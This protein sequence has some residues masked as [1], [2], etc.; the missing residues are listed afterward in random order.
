M[1][2]APFVVLSFI[3]IFFSGCEASKCP[4][5]WTITMGSCRNLNATKYQG[6][7]YEQSRSTSFIPG[8]LCVCTT[9]NYTIDT[10]PAGYVGVH[11]GCDYFKVGGPPTVLDGKAAVTSPQY[12]GLS[13]SFF[14]PVGSDINYQVVD[15][16]Y[17]SYTIIVTCTKDQ[18]D[19][20]I[21]I[22]SR[23]KVIDPQLFN[24]LLARIS[25]MGFDYSD[26][27][28]TPQGT[29]CIGQGY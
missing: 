9:A 23:A 27:I 13:V 11:N 3:V 15:T 16:D 14:G 21:W 28:L 29:G 18:K 5:N 7:W 26:K 25:N 4:Q 24:T 22:L 10:L 2:A 17:E 6:V 8:L 12:C 1:S 19:D 20:I